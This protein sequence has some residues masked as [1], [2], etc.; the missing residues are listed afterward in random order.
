MFGI[1]LNK[2]FQKSAATQAFKQTVQRT[3]PAGGSAYSF[4][5]PTSSIYTPFAVVS[6]TPII[7]EGFD[8]EDID[9]KVFYLENDPD[10]SGIAKA[11][12]TN[13]GE[14]DISSIDL[15]V[16]FTELAAT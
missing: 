3:I 9:V 15:L 2:C 12:I 16:S 7:P 10:G 6:V 11:I 5:V 13:N 1:K 4:I 14:T 8:A